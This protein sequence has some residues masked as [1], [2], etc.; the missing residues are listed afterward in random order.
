VDRLG[1]F[2][3]ERSQPIRGSRIAILGMAYKKDVD[4][5]RESPAL[6]LAA[7]LWKRGAIVTYSDPHVPMLG[8][9]GHQQLPA[10]TSQPLT[11]EY[12]RDQD[13]VLI[14]TDHS[15]FDYELIVRHSSLVV[16]TRNATKSVQQGQDRIRRA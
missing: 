1:E 16:D 10:M 4:D 9:T 5:F 11:P 8:H 7:L 6:E 2:L 15:A 13:C 12:L 3:N 14:A